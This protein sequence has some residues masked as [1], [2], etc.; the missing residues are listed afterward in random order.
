LNTNDR[1][2]IWRCNAR[3]DNISPK[4]VNKMAKAGCRV[5]CVGVESTSPNT[6]NFIEKGNSIIN[7][8]SKI[9]KNI[10]IFLDNGIDLQISTIIGFPYEG[11]GEM[12]RTTE[13]VLQLQQMGIH[14]SVGPVVAYPGSRLWQMYLDGKI[15]L[16][17]TNNPYLRRH[18]GSLFASYFSDDPY[19]DPFGFL[20]KHKFIEQ[21]H[22]ESTLL[23]CM[24]LTR[25][26]ALKHSKKLF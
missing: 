16:C 3:I 10:I 9:M 12:Q 1:E 15:D 8:L 23:Q 6:L 13:F 19:L 18:I 26:G 21:D 22:L 2:V 24:D 17:K 14:T 7:Y 4:T 25:I 11:I 20:P 5:I